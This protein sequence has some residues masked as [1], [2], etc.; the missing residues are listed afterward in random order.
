MDSQQT[1]E[2]AYTNREFNKRP[3]DNA[4]KNLLLLHPWGIV[5]KYW[6]RMYVWRTDRSSLNKIKYMKTVCLLVGNWLDKKNKNKKS[7]NMRYD[8]FHRQICMW[9]YG[10]S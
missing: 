10:M 3:D 7:E 1:K 6:G 2:S 8:Y 5:W 9:L 4:E